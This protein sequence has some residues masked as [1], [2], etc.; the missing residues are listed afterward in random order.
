[1]APDKPALA[2]ETRYGGRVGLAR[3]VPIWQIGRRQIYEAQGYSQPPVITH[4]APDWLRLSAALTPVV[5]VDIDFWT[6]ESQAV[7]GRFTL[8]N[9]SAQA[10]GVQ[11]DFVAQ[12]ATTRNAGV[13]IL[14]LSLQNGQSALQLGRM[15][16]LQPVL[17]L[18]GATGVTTRPRLTRTL[19][20]DP[21]TETALRWTLASMPTRDESLLLA[22]KWLSQ[23]WAPH[24][25]AIE[26]RLRAQPE[27]ETGRKTW[28]AA[29]AWSQQIVLRS[30]LGAT[31][32]LPYAS[33]VSAR[34][35]LDGYPL[36]GTH[37]SGFNAA[38]G[39]QSAPDALLIAP[40]VALAAP[41]LAKG[42]VRNFLAVQRH[43]GFID[44]RPGLDGQRTGVL[45]PPLL[46]TLT[47]TVYHFTRDRSLL[48][49]AFPRLRQFFERWFKPDMDR[50]G[51]GL[52]EWSQVDQ[53]AFGGPLFGS[54]S[55][56]GQ[57][58]DISTVESPDLAA[59]LVHEVGALIR[60]AEILN[61]PEDVAALT[62]R[63]DALAGQLQALWDAGAQ[64]FVLR[65]RATHSTPSGEVIYEAKGDQPLRERTD[66]PYASRLLLRAI[67]GLTRK[68]SLSCT[69]EGVDA[70]GKPAREEIP[71]DAFDW[72]RSAGAAT[73]RTVWTALTSV[74][75]SGLSR[76][77]TVQV[78]TVNLRQ[79]DL[80]QFVPL[81]TDALS[82][83]Q[84]DALIATLSD[85]PRWWRAYG[86]SASPA[87]DPT[88][89]TGGNVVW[90][91]WNML[92]AWA[93]MDHGRHAEAADLFGRVIA[94]QIR[95]LES[96]QSFRASYHADTGDG[97]GDT[98]V[99]MGA[100]SLAW[101]ARLFGAYVLAPDLAVITGPLAFEGEHM[102]WTQHGVR[103]TRGADGTTVQFPSGGEVTLPPHADPQV[104][105]DPSGM[106]TPLTPPT[107]PEP[108]T[109]GDLP[110]PA[111]EEQ[112]VAPEPDQAADAGPFFTLDDDPLPEID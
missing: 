75:F 83:E 56:A 90:P 112:P 109:D 9:T 64:T 46:A 78:G 67:G 42:I 81:W 106:P 2:L 31:G 32:S 5:Q 104:V 111:A 3:L 7:G 110:F 84:A 70:N 95:C 17:L 30:F 99:I 94:A 44:A 23:N 61:R 73:T 35:P 57:G 14:F 22:H 101:F 24:L 65:D 37:A 108:V 45:A 60:I 47:H 55:T 68:P 18:E 4:F 88:Y 48:T 59:Y 13:Q 43:D 58:L 21:G 79:Q 93:L 49:D 50:D 36:S 53:G 28:D 26:R 29:L 10:V 39:G 97:I 1:G 72:Y 86:L 103:I 16:G 77:Y 105:R 69:I 102:A 63:R 54:G 25:A 19:T 71:G 100:V 27:I 98:G 40:A 6:M 82:D 15:E 12:I 91:Y 89:A 38:W 74:K 96:G 87:D 33:F 66:L 51:D 76:V 80:G 41:D 34:R 20:L 11:L 92:L 85:P 62:A 8:R 107:E 52:P